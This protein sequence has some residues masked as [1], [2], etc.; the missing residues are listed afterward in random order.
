MNVS[1][2]NDNKILKELNEKIIVKE[3][4]EMLEVSDILLDGFG[5]DSAF[6]NTTIEEDEILLMNTDRSGINSAYTLGIANGECVGDFGVSHAISD[7]IASGGQPIAV[8]IALLLPEDITLGFVKEVMIGA[9]K[10]AKKYGAIL[11]AG[12]TKKNSKFAMVVTA[13]GKAK[14]DERLTR[15]KVKKDDL[16]VVTGN[17][18][19]MV[20]G[21]L[22]IKKNIN[23][24]EEENELFK[25]ALIYQNPPYKLGLE[26]SKAK[27]ASTCTDNSD[28]LPSSI[29]SLCNASGLGAIIEESELPIHSA[30]LN[31]ARNLNIRPIQLTLAGGD[32]QYLY[33]VPKKN[34]GEV[35]KIAKEVNHKITII[36]KFIK[37]KKVI[38]KTLENE[39]K[40]LNRIENDRFSK[41]SGNSYFE[42][43]ANKME[44][45]GDKIDENLKNSLEE[46]L[47]D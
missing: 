44:C 4:T 33:S 10:A 40:I 5:H 13:V 8:T 15:S 30:S 46:I 1:E 47:N 18:G 22:A 14:K 26:L 34:I 37:E 38:V 23:V 7:I 19:T 31:I 6:V 2:N 9:Q 17:L 39:Y 43:L 32:W 41:N 28:G 36:G 16:L 3:I 35:Y 12:D 45:F 21:L 29:Y 25:D 27:I 42:A 11:A 24:S 20:S